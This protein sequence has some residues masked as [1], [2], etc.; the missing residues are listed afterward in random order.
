MFTITV[1]FVNFPEKIF[2]QTLQKISQFFDKIDW[3][4]IKENL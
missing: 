2:W 4:Q 1:S 3:Q